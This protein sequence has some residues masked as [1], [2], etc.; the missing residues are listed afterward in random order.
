MAVI[1]EWNKGKTDDLYKIY[2]EKQ[3]FFF[4]FPKFKNK[5]FYEWL[6]PELK[7]L[8]N[9]G[10]PI[11]EIILDQFGREVTGING[12]IGYLTIAA[13]GESHKPL[14]KRVKTEL[15]RYQ[16]IILSHFS[17]KKKP[18]MLKDRT[19]KFST[20]L[21]PSLFGEKSRIVLQISNELKMKVAKLP[22]GL[23]H[24]DLHGGNLVVEKGKIRAIVDWENVSWQVR[25]V[26]VAKI[27]AYSLNTD[28]I[29]WYL[30]QLGKWFTLE[31]V[32]LDNLYDLTIWEIATNMT[33]WKGKDNDFI[34]SILPKLKELVKVSKGGAKDL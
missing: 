30:N 13:T 12:K 18:A 4:K 22:K 29:Q 33:F 31:K 5:D 10:V 23:V 9:K 16:G 7:I 32:E 2:S 21:D 17:G 24:C 3:N 20:Q 1:R 25:A 15:A 8:R 19:E 6:L 27:I 34:K 26:D 11:P 28:E 14:T